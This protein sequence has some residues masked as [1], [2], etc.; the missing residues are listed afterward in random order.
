[1]A[2]GRPANSLGIGPVHF[3]VF[4]LLEIPLVNGPRLAVIRDGFRLRL[5]HFHDSSDPDLVQKS[6]DLPHAELSANVIDFAQIGF[7][8]IQRLAG[9]ILLQPLKFP[10]QL[11]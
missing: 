6:I 2:R 11:F 1:V 4:D 3:Q 7:L 10:T 8:N 5:L 9:V